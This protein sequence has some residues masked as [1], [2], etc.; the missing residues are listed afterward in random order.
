LAGGFVRHPII[1]GVRLA[2]YFC[3]AISLGLLTRILFGYAELPDYAIAVHRTRRLRSTNFLLGALAWTNKPQ[4]IASICSQGTIHARLP[5]MWT[6]QCTELPF[7]RFHRA[8]ALGSKMADQKLPR[9]E[10]ISNHSPFRSQC[11]RKCCSDRAEY[12]IRWM[13]ISDSATM[14]TS[15]S[16]RQ[17]FGLAAHSQAPPAADN[18]G[19]RCIALFSLFSS[20]Q[21]NRYGLYSV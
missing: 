1:W 5:G 11:P 14:G 6:F 15:A 20:V 2:E 8:M 17:E 4:N 7:I 16:P 19:H 18:L 10:G 12:V 9:S 3:G 21:L 13:N